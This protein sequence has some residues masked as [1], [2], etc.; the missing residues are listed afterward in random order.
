MPFAM[1]SE[2]TEAGAPD[3]P[4]NYRPNY[5]PPATF[6][7]HQ[8][9]CYNISVARINVPLPDVAIERLRDLARREMRDPRSQASLLIQDGLRRAGVDPEGSPTT[10]DVTRPRPRP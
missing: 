6:T 9:C 7:R 1:R 4:P 8:L 2:K 5:R 10:R 3:V